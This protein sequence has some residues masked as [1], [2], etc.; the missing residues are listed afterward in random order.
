MARKTLPIKELVDYANKQLAR[1]DEYANNVEFK[2]GICVMIE[3]ALHQA[4]AYKGYSNNDPND[5]KF[6]TL[7]DYN[8]TYWL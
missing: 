4:E 6:G 2:S 7:G 1:T 3:F 5:C 8:R